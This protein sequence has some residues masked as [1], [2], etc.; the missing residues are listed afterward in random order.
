MPGALKKTLYIGSS[1][2]E[3]NRKVDHNVTKGQTSKIY[4]RSANTVLSEAEK[5]DKSLDEER[6]YVLF[7]KYLALWKAVKAAKDYKQNKV[8]W[9]FYI[10]HATKKTQW[11][12]P[13]KAAYQA[14]QAQQ[15]TPT[16]PT[17]INI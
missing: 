17:S 11:V 9:L 8:G 3:L 5:A 4:A 14:Q 6:A 1:L 10:N 16:Q 7:M 13:R 15:R 2:E 12:D